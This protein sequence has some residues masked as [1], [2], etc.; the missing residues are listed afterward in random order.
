[1]LVAKRVIVVIFVLA[2]AVAAGSMAGCGGDLPSDAVAKVGDVTITEDVFNQR[3][4]EFGSQYGY[5]E[6]T[7]E[8]ETWKAFKG[9]VLEYLITY[10][11]AAQK[12]EEYEVTVTDVDVQGEIDT[13][14]Q[15]YYSGD[16]AAFTEELTAAD[17][18]LDQLK[19]NYKESM[20]LQAVY[21]KVTADVTEVS[22]EEIAAYYEDNKDSYYVEETRTARHILIA[23][24]GE[25]KNETTSTTAPW[26]SSTTEST[27]TTTE[28]TT[29]TSL[30]DADWA[31]ALAT[32][33]TVR[34]LLDDGGDW[35]E[36]AAE[37]SD[38]SGTANS[39]GE[40]GAVSKGEM[41][42]EFEDA[43]FS[44][45]LNQ[46]SEPV[47]STYGYHVIQ[48]TEISE[49]YQQTLEEVSEDI[50]SKLLAEKQSEAWA[51]WIESTKAEL[52]VVYR[53]D[54]QTTTTVSTEPT[55]TTNEPTDTTIGAGDTT[56]T[57]G[58][59][60]TTAAETPTTAKP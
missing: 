8:A 59:T 39:G 58:Q 4:E 26:G 24:G 60:I 22:D 28:S 18:T 1:V 20:L 25:E 44:L 9:D 48:V 54:M 41:V 45:E 2:L 27:T 36:L 29:T 33:E 32:A 19:A 31:D 40:L 49:A 43:V 10:E 3:V 38:D 55:A 21:E 23:P 16:E 35:T 14:I 57:V 56:T 52:N 53:E 46:V 51:T 47:K 12:A 7:T 11:M 50:T 37:Y 5:S 42:Q 30:T 6:D 13:I 17:M 15:S 34:E